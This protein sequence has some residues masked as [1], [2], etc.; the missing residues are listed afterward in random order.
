MNAV[1]KS[2]C[3]EMH[4]VALAATIER[5]YRLRMN[6]RVQA[7]RRYPDLERI[8]A[9]SLTEFVP[10]PDQAGAFSKSCD[11]ED[12]RAVPCRGSFTQG[13]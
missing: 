8:Q 5:V 3:R 7:Y 13:V 1:L 10:R 11:G 12:L 9:R 6:R 2:V 4:C